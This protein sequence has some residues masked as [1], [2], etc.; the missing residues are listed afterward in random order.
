MWEP[1][2]KHGYHALTY[3][4]LVGEVVR[5]A[6]G[7]TLGEVLAK[8]VSGPLGLDLWIGLPEDRRAAGLPAHPRRTSPTEPRGTERPAP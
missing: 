2:T 4:W 3:G 8:E 1:G 5:R 7:N 6:T